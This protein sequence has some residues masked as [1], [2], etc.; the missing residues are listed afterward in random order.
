MINNIR[1]SHQLWLKIVIIIV[2]LFGVFFRVTN[3]DKK[4]YWH[5]EVYTSL[6][7]SGYTEEYVTNQLSN[8]NLVTPK[9]IQKFLNLQP[10]TTFTDTLKVLKTAPEHPPLYYLS[11]RF[12]QDIF[13]S[14]I[15]VNRGVA[16]FFSLLCF[17]SIYWL[18]LEL[19]GNNFVALITLGF[20]SISPFHVLYAQEARQ[21]SLWTLTII[22]SLLFFLKAI[23]SNKK[24]HWLLYSATLTLSFYTALL[25]P[26]L[27]ITN[28]IYLYLSKLN[29][30]RQ[31]KNN[32]WFYSLISFI[33]FTPWAIIFILNPLILVRRTNWLNQSSSIDELGFTL[34]KNFMRLFFDFPLDKRIF[35]SFALILIYLI[36]KTLLILGKTTNKYKYIELYLILLIGIPLLALLLPDLI[37]GGRRSSISRYLIPSYLGTHLVVGYFFY[38]KIDHYKSQIWS[39]ILVIIFTV[40]MTSNIMLHNA[41]ISWNK[42]HPSHPPQVSKIINQSEKPLLIASL[43]DN[44]SSIIALSYQLKLDVKLHL[45]QENTELKYYPEFSP[46]YLF[47][48]SPSLMNKVENVYNAKLEQKHKLVYQVVLQ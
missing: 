44:F 39:I 47:N 37:I 23:K 4:I 29:F 20:F 42:N 22:L 17:P 21:Y 13:G 15:L 8:G 2:I 45:F 27:F 43:E 26:L 1:S 30:S 7:V 36:L 34:S 11:L 33:L 9:D 19:F 16:V 10:E 18:S 14:S 6:R 25:S 24:S 35:F 32:F 5:D 46:I 48:P 40:S 3:I 12:V 28:T 31:I 38:Y 41:E